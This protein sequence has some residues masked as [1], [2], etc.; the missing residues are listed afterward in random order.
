MHRLA[1][2][3]ARSSHATPAAVDKSPSASN[4]KFRQPLVPHLRGKRQ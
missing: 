4:T 2:R 1:H 3:V